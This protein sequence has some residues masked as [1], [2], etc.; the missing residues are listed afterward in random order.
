V[1]QAI[2][3]VD[4]K[5]MK[6]LIN[7]LLGCGISS[8]IFFVPYPSLAAN[9]KGT[10]I[11]PFG[12]C[13]YF[14]IQDRYGSYSEAEWYGGHS[15]SDGDIIYGNFQSYGFKN[16]YDN[17]SHSNIKVW[18]D[19]YWASQDDSIQYLMD[20]CDGYTYDPSVFDENTNVSHPVIY[21]ISTTTQT[22]TLQKLCANYAPYLIWDLTSN[23]CKI[24]PSIWR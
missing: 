17:A 11:T 19:D 16:L 5:V 6:K 21:P 10:A 15:P 1:P 23:E 22:Q 9:Q 18:L 8:F 7:I 24:S 2:L 20:H 3:L 14:L 4:I 13:D 12:S